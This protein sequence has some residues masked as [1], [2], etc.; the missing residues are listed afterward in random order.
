M[1]HRSRLTPALLAAAALA[2]LPT[3]AGAATLLQ[4]DFDTRVNGDSGKNIDERERY[5]KTS[6]FNT[7]LADFGTGSQ[8]LVI[9]SGLTAVN[10]NNL[11]NVGGLGDGSPNQAGPN[12]LSRAIA[13]SEFLTFTV[14][15]K[16]GFELDLAGGFVDY[17]GTQNGAFNPADT[18]KG[19]TFTRIALFTSVDGFSDASNAV[20]IGE[21]N[22][23]NQ[24]VRLSISA[25]ATRFNDLTTPTEF[26]LYFFAENDTRTFAAGAGP[27]FDGSDPAQFIALDG[28][29]SAVTT[30]I[31]EPTAALA[32]LALLGGIGLRRSRA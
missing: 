30:V 28:Q 9:G 14:A 23:A 1:P 17:T 6:T 26:R 8:G 21:Y 27:R 2:T 20:A 18:T 32:G 16:S 11:Y 15:P 12:N 4:F 31:P 7:N 29:V 19:S 24:D 25:T 3:A 22:T 5:T 13:E 10:G